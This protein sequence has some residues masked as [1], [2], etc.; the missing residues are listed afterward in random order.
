MASAV[1]YDVEEH[2]SNGGIIQDD[3]D[4][5]ASSST[6]TCRTG[7]RNLAAKVVEARRNSILFSLGAVNGLGQTLASSSRWKILNPVDPE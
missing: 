1:Q 6:P 3:R 5:E 2:Y 7:V 4:R